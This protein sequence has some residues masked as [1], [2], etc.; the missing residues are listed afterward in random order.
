MNFKNFKLY[1]PLLLTIFAVGFNLVMLFAETRIKADL[2]DNVFALT[3]ISRM[4]KI[5]DDGFNLPLLLDHWIPEFNMGFPVFSYYQHIPSLVIVLLHRILPFDLITT[6][7]WFKYLM[8]SAFPLVIY[9]SGRKFGLSRIGAA[10][11]S[12]VSTLLSTQYL[13]GTDYNAL[14]FRGSGMYTQLWGMFFLPLAVSCIYDSVLNN[15]GYI[16]AVIF[17]AL[18]F[19]GHLVFGYI[20]VL[21]TPIILISII[22]NGMSLRAKRSNPNGIATARR[23]GGLRDDIVYI[24]RLLLILSTAFIL[25]AYWFIPII[26][27]SN[28]QNKSLWD[29]L[30]KFNSYGAMQI[31]KWLFN[32]QI[33]D[34]ERFPV[35]TILVAMGFFFGLSKKQILFPLLFL[36]WLILYFGRYTFGG[37]F[38]LL[39][40]SEG[41]HVH[42]LVNGVHMAGIFLVGMAGEWVWNSIFNIQYPISN[43]NTT[44]KYQSPIINWI[45][46]IGNWSWTLVIGF[47]VI[48]GIIFSPAIKERYD[49]LAFNRI[50]IDSNMAYY[51]RDKPDF[52]KV[53]NKIREL[54][55]GR[56]Y[57]GRPGNW[58]RNFSVGTISSYFQASVNNLSTLGFAP[59]SWSLN[60]DIEQFFSEYDPAYYNLFNVNYIV[61]PITEKFSEADFAKKIGKY[62]KFVLFQVKTNGNF[63]FINSDVLIYTKKNDRFNLDRLWLGSDLMKQ[64][65]HPTLTFDWKQPPTNYPYAFTMDDL[66]NY[67]LGVPDKYGHDMEMNIF[68]IN[69][70]DTILK[71][72][73]IATPSGTII[74]QKDFSA[75]VKTDKNS[76][77]MLKATYHPFWQAKIDGSEV[78]KLWV[79][80]AFMA[81]RVP[82][83]THRVEFNYYPGWYK[84]VLIFVSLLTIP[85]L[86]LFLKKYKIYYNTRI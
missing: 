77:L 32:G 81:I 61:A 79:E 6:F 10:I 15:R 19:S 39:P 23:F 40:M 36:F 57:F 46:K 45:L 16:K 33:F 73:P 75:D 60:T 21:S 7:N 38:D 78:E 69:P 30:T 28:Y 59:E 74:R 55:P 18:A 83:G 44:N 9:Y 25:L 42:R 48:I 53:V 67:R 1:W 58:G 65:S 29:D 8:L 43:S 12:L 82:P 76:I 22:I 34:N 71:T 52:Q 86:Y 4:N 84:V 20:A 37:L 11:S 51:V 70:F 3:L 17:L 35:V 50:S 64:K 14:V 56:V 80:P 72:M 26:L 13:Y 47:I 24:K 27:N 63:E 5:L 54:G 62:G 2:N 68:G 41:L 85:A 31:L 49:Y 66:L